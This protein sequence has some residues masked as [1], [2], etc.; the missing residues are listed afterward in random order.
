MAE[1]SPKDARR[2]VGMRVDGLENRTL[3]RV[4]GL[5]VDAD[6]GGARWVV[7][8]LGPL[9]GHTAIPF[10][11][12]AEAA[13]RLWAGYERGWVRAAPTFKPSEALAAGEELEL[14]AHWGI[15]EGRGRTAE[16]FPRADDEITA[17]P[18][19]IAAGGVR[20]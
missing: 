15:G 13:G 10:D 1:L 20:S 11:H 17:V 3:G 5:L 18:A 14:C 7:I 12:V 2:W 4:A 8:R 6:D 16:V 19:G 9:A